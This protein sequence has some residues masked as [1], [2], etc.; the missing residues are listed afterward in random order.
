MKDKC[1]WCGSKLE[2][3]AGFCGECSTGPEKNE[4]VCNRCRI[5]LSS[6]EKIYHLSESS[7]CLV[8]SSEYCKECYEAE[9]IE[10]AKWKQ[11]YK[12]EEKAARAQCKECRKPFPGIF[13]KKRY[14][15]NSLGDLTRDYYCEDC[16]LALPKIEKL[17]EPRDVSDPWA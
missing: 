5:K 4:L 15:A 14:Q 10:R 9:L 2:P 17:D 3:N 12:E 8:Y 16:F 1:I 7:G 11:I 13:R 6:N